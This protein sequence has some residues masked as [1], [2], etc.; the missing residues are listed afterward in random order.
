MT[1]QT[2]ANKAPAKKAP[3]KKAPATSAAKKASAESGAKSTVKSTAKTASK[4]AAP[5]APQPAAQAASPAPAPAPASAATLPAAAPTTNSLAIVAFV[6]S[7]FGFVSGLG[8]IA[9][10]ICGHISLSQIKRS[11]ESGRGLAIAA[12]VVGYAML[13][14]SIVMF[15]LFIL[16][17]FVLA[18]TGGGFTG[19]GMHGW[20]S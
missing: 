6:L 12:V 7:M 14:V 15:A 8:F 5:A 4:T 13:F 10:I 9:G 20:S 1:E 19:P 18:S 17:F 2:P 11:N 3:A 16:F